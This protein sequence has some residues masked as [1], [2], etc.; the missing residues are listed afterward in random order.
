MHLN[1][2]RR[3]TFWMILF[4]MLIYS[5]SRGNAMGSSF[6]AKTVAAIA[7]LTLL[8]AAL[9][10]QAQVSFFPFGEPSP[11]AKTRDELDAVGRVSDET[12]AQTGIRLAH[13]FIRDYPE[14][15][16][17]EFVHISLLHNFEQTHDAQQVRETAETILHLNPE[18]VDALLALAAYRLEHAAP[19]EGTPGL[20]SAREY[21]QHALE[22][23][24]GVKMPETANRKQWMEKKK[25]LLGKV[26]LYLGLAAIQE[27]ELDEGL[28]HLI[29]ATEFD[30][31]GSYF[32]RLATLYE[33][34]ASYA[35]ALE[36]AERAR[37]LG[38]EIVTRLAER[39]IARLRSRTEDHGKH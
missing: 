16:F 8:I 5:I 31:Q 24:R 32:Y 6:R 18:S 15:D 13:A 9:P 1:D 29:A 19:G 22:R 11:Q 30:P 3:D 2:F 14:S 37:Q 25:S 28:R 20:L 17:R 12:D 33:A 4:E 10:L 21:A 23:I 27:K 36:A 26:S 35:D 34:R 7:R 39:Q 38:P